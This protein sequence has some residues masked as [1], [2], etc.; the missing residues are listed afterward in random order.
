[1]KTLAIGVFPDM[2]LD[3]A[4]ERL[5]EA[6]KLLAQHIDPCEQKKQVRQAQID[7]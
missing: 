3:E 7:S 2:S 1:R 4:R 5:R 6:K